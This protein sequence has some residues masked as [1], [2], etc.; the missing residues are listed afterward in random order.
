VS[1]LATSWPAL[2]T[3]ASVAVTDS[4]ALGGAQR[5][6]VAELAQLDAACS[7][8]RDDS[9]ITRLNRN[10]GRPFEAGPLLIEAIEVALRAA[11]LSDGIVDPTIGEALI[12]AGYDRDFAMLRNEPRVLVGRRVPGWSCVSVRRDTGTVSMPPGVTLDLGATAKALGADRA[13]KRAASAAGADVGVLVNLGGDIS[14]CGPAPGGGWL[15]RVTDD[16]RAPAD[17]PGQTVTIASGAL[18]TSSTTVRRWGEGAHHIID[19]RTGLPADTRWRTVSVAAATCVDA[20]VA[21]T[22]AIVLGEEAP[23]WLAER[24]LPARL[25]DLGGDVVTTSGWPAAEVAA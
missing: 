22:A 16:H 7:R 5:A 25:V 8:F 11:R 23:D 13:A 10:G 17:A 3:T 19:P 20:N 9:E 12:L 15:V 2:G 14:T 4:E 18:A 21:S 1:T 6:V 24:G